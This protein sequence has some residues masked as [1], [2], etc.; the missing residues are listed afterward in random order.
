MAARKRSKTPPR[1]AKC[2]ILGARPSLRLP[3]LALEPHH[4]DVIALALIALGIFLA[5]VAYLGWAGGTLGRGVIQAFRF[6]VGAIGYAVP[7]ALVVGGGM[8]LLRE[9]RPPARPIRTGSICL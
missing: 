7:V 3:S 5:G 6:L 9:L 1:R 2:S 4:V 8:L